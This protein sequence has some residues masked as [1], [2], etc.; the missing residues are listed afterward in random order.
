MGKRHYSYTDDKRDRYLAEGRCQRRG[1]DYLP[2]ITVHDFPSRGNTH[3]FR[4]SVFGLVRHLFSDLEHKTMLVADASPLTTDL[5]EQFRLPIEDTAAIAAS[6]GIEHPR[7]RTTGALIDLTT[8]L[9]IDRRTEDGRL[10]VVP[11]SVKY[12]KDFIDQNKVEHEEIQRRFWLK[13]GVRLTFVTDDERCLPKDLIANLRLLEPHRSLQIENQPYD[14][15]LVDMQSR[16]QHAL[17]R[18]NTAESL[19][20][21]CVRFEGENGLPEGNGLKL[22]YYFI[23]RRALIT[24]LRGTILRRRNVLEIRPSTAAS[25]HRRVA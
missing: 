13:H 14:G 20:D 1:A 22:A 15:Y 24:P 6:L 21:F 19:S 11:V 12:Q 18:A 17:G 10:R 5:R 25:S 8:D 3:R 4:D 16:I 2:W 9:V 7:D 23:F